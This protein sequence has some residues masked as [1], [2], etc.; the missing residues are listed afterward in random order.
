MNIAQ[1]NEVLGEGAFVQM[2]FDLNLECARIGAFYRW[3]QME[4]DYTFIYWQT[5]VA[6]EG[7]TAGAMMDK[8]NFVGR[9]DQLILLLMGKKAHQAAT[10]TQPTN[11]PMIPAPTP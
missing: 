7:L 10:L 1:W 11:P 4:Y 9:C 2:R 3:E 5:V 8:L 6:D